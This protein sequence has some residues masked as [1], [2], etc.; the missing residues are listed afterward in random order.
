MG[1]LIFIVTFSLVTFLTHSMDDLEI[2]SF[3]K[4]PAYDKTEM[5]SFL[6]HEC[7]FTEQFDDTVFAS[8]N[9]EQWRTLG[10]LPKL[11]K[12][13]L[14]KKTINMVNDLTYDTLRGTIACLICAGAHPDQLAFHDDTA[15]R[16]ATMYQDDKMIRFL[17]QKK[18]NPNLGSEPLF[19][20]KSLEIAQLFHAADANF[21][22]VGSLKRTL[23]HN[24]VTISYADPE[25]IPFLIRQGVDVNQVDSF[26]DTPLHTLCDSAY[27][28]RDI[29]QLLL[30]ARLLV[31][32][33][34]SLNA[35]NNHQITALEILKT[36][37]GKYQYE[38]LQE[39]LESL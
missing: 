22:V 6:Y 34:A 38:R 20:I 35:K 13:K 26:S 2:S 3:V 39:Y 7:Q 25:L 17:L 21:K 15:L 1:N 28:Y 19:W 30:K 12:N 24:A 16:R 5:N 23:L 18:A 36:H 9:K 14:L 11:K 8:L 32:A 37:K 4:V 29:A 10:T 31:E 33:G 27:A